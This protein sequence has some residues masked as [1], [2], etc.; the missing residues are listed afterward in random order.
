VGKPKYWGQ[1]VVKSDKC[2]GI[3]NYWEHVP[4]LPPKS[5]PMAITKVIV[6]PTSR[7]YLGNMSS[8]DK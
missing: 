3:L 7:T 8:S 4:G 5:T 6:G 2:M 1:K